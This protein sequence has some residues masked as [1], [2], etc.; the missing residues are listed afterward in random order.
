ML[1]G[2]NKITMYTKILFSAIPLISIKKRV[3]TNAI[4]EPYISDA[5]VKFVRFIILL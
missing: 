4:K 5:F 1:P 2:I 3:T